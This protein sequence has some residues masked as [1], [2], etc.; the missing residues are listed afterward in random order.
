MKKKHNNFTSLHMKSGFP[1]PRN[2]ME[3]Y[4]HFPSV[5]NLWNFVKIA[6]N[7]AFAVKIQ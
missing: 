2:V 3:L 4:F 5:E 7:T 6:K 1:Q